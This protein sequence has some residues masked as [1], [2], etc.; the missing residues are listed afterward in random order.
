MSVGFLRLTVRFLVTSTSTWTTELLGLGPSGI[1]NKECAVVLEE[2]LLELVLGVLIHVL[3][4]IGDDGLGDGL[5]DGVD[6]R[7][8]TTTGDA[9]TDVDTSELVG[10][11]DQEGLVDL[12]TAEISC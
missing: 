4:V 1:G 12:L 2:S 6:L 9:N 3:L 8:L 7:G 11:D 5:T 10:A